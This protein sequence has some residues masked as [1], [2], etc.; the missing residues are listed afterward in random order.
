MEQTSMQLLIVIDD[1][2]MIIIS[3]P[4]KPIFFSESAIC[5]SKGK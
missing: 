3:V 5:W 2:P 4:T 1:V